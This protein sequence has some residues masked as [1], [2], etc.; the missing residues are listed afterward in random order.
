MKERKK[1][2]KKEKGN[3]SAATMTT[4]KSRIDA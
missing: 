4:R 3:G 2:E 1:G